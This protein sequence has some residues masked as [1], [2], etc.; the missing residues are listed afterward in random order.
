MARAIIIRAQASG[1]RTTVRL[2]MAH[3]MESGQR[4]DPAGRR[5][6]AWHIQEV[7]VLLNGVPVLT[8]LCGPSMAKDPFLQF[9]LRG[10]RP[11][12]TVTVRWVDNR[13]ERRSDDAKV[14]A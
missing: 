1:D 10:A 2:L 8:A 6:A 12:D 4:I 5:V 9:V 7:S 14:Q 11:G 3:D 13:G